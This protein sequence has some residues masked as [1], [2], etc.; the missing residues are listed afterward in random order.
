M[1]R[2]PCYQKNFVVRVG[3]KVNLKKYSEISGEGVEGWS[4]NEVEQYLREGLVSSVV[5]RD[6]EIEVKGSM[7][8]RERR[9]KLKVRRSVFAVELKHR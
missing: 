5:E 1:T 8:D 2:I 4:G 3:K 9:E 6:R 7:V